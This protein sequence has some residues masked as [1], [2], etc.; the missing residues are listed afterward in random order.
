MAF[1]AWP[2]V[3]RVQGGEQLRESCRWALSL[4]VPQPMN[5]PRK[6]CRPRNW[7]A[8]SATV[9]SSGVEKSRK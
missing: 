9:Y 8:S 3:S 2:T 4:Y 1:R 5:P 7:G 6:P